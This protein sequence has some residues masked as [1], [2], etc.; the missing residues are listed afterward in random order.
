MTY[1]K[2]HPSNKSFGFLFAGVCF[3]LSAYALYHKADELKVYGWLMVSVIVCV[4][5][6]AAPSLLTPLNRAWMKLGEVLGK[7]I[8]P[9]VLGVIFFLLITPL[10]LISRMLGRDELRLKNTRHATCWIER[11]HPSPAGDTFKNQF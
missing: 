6:I 4:V 10:A 8:S 9:L 3:I 7:L 1:K 11:E 2:Q 5:A